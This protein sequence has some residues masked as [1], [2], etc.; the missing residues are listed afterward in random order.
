MFFDDSKTEALIMWGIETAAVLCE[1]ALYR[2]KARQQV[3]RARELKEVG[4]QTK[5]LRKRREGEDDEAPSR[6]QK[7]IRQRYYQLKEDRAADKTLQWYL[8]LG[9]TVN[10]LLSLFVLAVILTIAQGGGLCVDNFN[11][12]NP[13]DLDQLSRCPLCTNTTGVCEICSD[14]MQQCFY[15]YS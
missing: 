10:I 15:P 8:G 7:E 14:D 5:S 3:L 11:V 6:E 4:R 2:V 13:F 12:P 9:C 1:L